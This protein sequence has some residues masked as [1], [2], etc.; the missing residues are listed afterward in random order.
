MRMQCL[1]E[2]QALADG[3]PLRVI[4]E[5]SLEATTLSGKQTTPPRPRLS[6]GSFSTKPVTA[7]VRGVI[8]GQV[9]A[10][11]VHSSR[12]SDGQ[13]TVRRS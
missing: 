10:L 5:W 11:D 2:R 1:A 12:P 7:Y 8:C 4:V 3:D 9:M 6:G 13:M